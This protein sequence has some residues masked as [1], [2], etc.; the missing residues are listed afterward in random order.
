GFSSDWDTWEP[1]E[2]LA[3]CQDLIKKFQS[4][5]KKVQGSKSPQKDGS[6]KKS[7]DK[8]DGGIKNS[9]K[10]DAINDGKAK[11]TPKKKEKKESPKAVKSSK[12]SPQ[13][14]E[15]EKASPAEKESKTGNKKSS[16]SKNEKAKSQKV[17]K[18]TEGK[19]VAEEGKG[20]KKVKKKENEEE[21][22]K[23]VKQNKVRVK[24]LKD[25]DKNLKM[26]KK[27]KVVLKRDLSGKFTKT[28]QKQIKNVKGKVQF[29]PIKGQKLKVKIMKPTKKDLEK[30]TFFTPKAAKKEMKSD[31]SSSMSDSSTKSNKDLKKNVKANRTT[32]KN[33]NKQKATLEK[34]TATKSVAKGKSPKKRKAEENEELLDV[35]LIS[36]SDSE[37]ETLYSLSVKSKKTKTDKS[38]SP[39]SKAAT[40]A[41]KSSGETPKKGSPKSKSA[42]SASAKGTS[43]NLTLESVK[44]KLEVKAIRVKPFSPSNDKSP[45]SS[46]KKKMRLI[47]S[48]RDKTIANV[49]RPVS[50]TPVFTSFRP[51]GTTNH[52]AGIT[53]ATASGSS[54]TPIEIGDVPVYHFTPSQLPISPS[55]MSYKSI[56]DNLP[57]QAPPKK[58]SR[59]FSQDDDS[60]RVERRISVRQSE[61]AFRYKEIV[62]RKCQRYTQIWLNTQTKLK[63]ALNPQVIQEFVSALNSAKYD[64]STLVMYSGLGNVF[65]SGIDLNFLISGERKVAVRQM[66]DA[67]RDFTK[68]LITFPKPIVA[69]VNG[70]AIGLGMTM[71]P[72]CDI[73]Y[74]SDKATFYL[75]YSQLSQTP[76][77]C[78]SYTL[79]LSVGMAMANELLIGG[80]RI[81][82]I[83]ACNL[84]LVSQ[85]FWPTSM[86][87]EVIPKVQSIA[88]NS[89]KALETTKLL[90]RSHQRTKL[91]LT[92]ESES[93][94]LL[95]RWQSMDCLKAIESFL[96]NERNFSL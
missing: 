30:M 26:G 1:L 28:Y 55:S 59:N 93:N 37:N 25:G 62:V 85:V 58:P 7:P 47:D 57:S 69:V 61:C 32:Q 22:T 29:K 14:K 23:K 96:S 11:G 54:A 12:K 34:Q 84:G 78:A 91:E 8:K 63:N 71:L 50:P 20:K 65:C 89:A 10:V 39:K 2:N 6:A 9:T 92:N 41:A 74:A 49:I 27:M 44:R 75:P 45:P 70:P 40:S 36:D 35:T 86:M 64:D 5:V 16:P 33:T 66:V 53:M 67:L 21:K 56:L 15:V 82:A 52:T 72:L 83:E 79:P 43:G 42:A 46:S 17:T 76:E 3:D 51:I 95:E 77:G 4:A 81:T 60:E 24:A 73:V 18:K 38:S 31:E 19:D 68:A 88:L 90:I 87:Q 80:R 13:K 94:L 48:M